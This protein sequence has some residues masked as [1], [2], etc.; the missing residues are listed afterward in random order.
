MESIKEKS[1]KKDQIKCESCQETI[2]PDQACY[3]VR[4]GYIDED[5]LTFLV[6]SDVAYF[7]TAC[8]VS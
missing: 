6:D 4:Y 7:C 3:Q 5:G 2:Q 1:T 8:G